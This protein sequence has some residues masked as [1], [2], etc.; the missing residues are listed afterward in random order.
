MSPAAAMLSRALWVHRAVGWLQELSLASVV[1]RDCVR[2][3][4]YDQ[5]HDYIIQSYPDH[6]R[7]P[8]GLLLGG[9]KFSYAFELF[10]DT[11]LPKAAFINY[12]EGGENHGR[13]CVR[14]A[15]ISAPISG[16]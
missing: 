9:V 1:A 14:V 13:C 11:R 5:L 12:E 6:D 4:Q 15:S 16:R 3:V 7:T 10:L 8:I 2:L